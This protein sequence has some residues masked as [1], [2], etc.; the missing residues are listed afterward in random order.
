MAVRWQDHRTDKDITRVV[1][2]TL[3]DTILYRKPQ[4]F[5]HVREM[6]DDRLLKTLMLR[7]VE[8]GDDQRDVCRNA[9]KT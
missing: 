6:A 9:I 8:I 7:M 3:M 5:R 4:L 1:D 2:D